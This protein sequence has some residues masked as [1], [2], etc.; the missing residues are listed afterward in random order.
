M[1]ADH[2]PPTT[3]PAAF[4]AATADPARPLLTWYDDATGDRAELSGATM[5]NWVAKTANLLR[6]GCGLGAGDTAV[7][8]A[9]PHWQTAAVL[10]GCWTAGLR[11]A[12]P[13]PAGGGSAA[14]VVFA[15]A[16]RLDRYAG[17]PAEVF[18]LGLA[19]LAAPMRAVPPGVADFVTEVR[20][21]GDHFQPAVPVGPQDPAV[22]VGPQA[23][24]TWFSHA[25]LCADAAARA[26]AAGLTPA[27]RVLVDVGAR[28]DPRD[29]LLAPLVVGAATVLCAH[30]DPE[31]LPHRLAAERVT[32]T[33][34]VAA[35]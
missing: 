24:A 20:G 26:A 28:P 3:V 31:S 16:D 25:E 13:P 35:P 12:D 15:A 33:V 29:W 1:P 5:A 2:A 11:V 14:E 34:G 30:L 32:A 4:A 10:L 22:P 9:P 17:G 21:H 18:G 7:V 6:D 8:D 23:P 19:P 27:A